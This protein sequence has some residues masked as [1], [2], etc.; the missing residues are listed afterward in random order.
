MVA[1]WQLTPRLSGRSKSLS[2]FSV[3]KTKNGGRR[4][5]FWN[6][7]WLSHQGTWKY[8]LTE[9]LINRLTR[10]LPNSLPFLAQFSSLFFS[11]I[12][13]SSRFVSNK[14]KTFL[15]LFFPSSPFF[16]F[17]YSVWRNFFSWRSSNL[18][19][20]ASS[21]LLVFLRKFLGCFAKNLKVT[22]TN[23]M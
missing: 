10:P 20:A 19:L 13:F 14:K 3:K 21:L 22:S 5:D 15:C 7:F 16:L 2:S 1:R 4:W 9:Q 17:F 12:F 18:L 23:V 8:L 11:F 6:R